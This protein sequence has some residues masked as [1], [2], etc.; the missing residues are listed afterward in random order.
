MTSF[1]EQDCE[2]LIE[3]KTA[4]PSDF[5]MSSRFAASRH[6]IMTS[7]LHLYVIYCLLALHGCWSV[8]S[9]LNLRGDVTRLMTSCGDDAGAPKFYPHAVVPPL[10]AAEQQSRRSDADSNQNSILYR[11]L[12]VFQGRATSEKSGVSWQDGAIGSRFIGQLKKILSEASEE[13]AVDGGLVDARINNSAQYEGTRQYY[14]SGRVENGRI[15]RRTVLPQNA[16]HEAIQPTAS[17]SKVTGSGR[18]RR[19]VTLADLEDD[20]FEPRDSDEVEPVVGPVVRS[21]PLEQSEVTRG[22]W[23]SDEIL[24]SDRNNNRRKKNQQQR[25]CRSQSQCGQFKHYTL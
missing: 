25:R 23:R 16:D 19:A 1:P 20:D 14:P 7:S 17:T 22:N 3:R 18:H 10:S 11:L 9:Y 5:K 8:T 21:D 13:S 6:V 2:A 15:E 12:E 24:S 4:S